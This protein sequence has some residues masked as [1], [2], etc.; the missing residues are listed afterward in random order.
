[1]IGLGSIFNNKVGIFTPEGK[2][3]AETPFIPD[4]RGLDI[5]F[6]PYYKNTVTNKEPVISEFLTL[7]LW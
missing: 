1:M 7:H 4:R 3:L 6:R 2:I 5:S